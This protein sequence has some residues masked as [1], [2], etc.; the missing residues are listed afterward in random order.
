MRMNAFENVSG[1]QFVLTSEVLETGIMGSRESTRKRIILPIHRSQ[2][3]RVQR[4]LNFLQPGT[5]IRP[6]M[7][8][9]GHA[10]ESLVVLKGKIRFFRFTQKGEVISSNILQAGS[11]HS[12]ADIEPRVWH[13]FTV[14]EPDSVL[15]ECK[16]GP[17]D[18]ETDKVY[19][20]WAPEEGAG[21]VNEWLEKLQDHYHG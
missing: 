11:A 18:A 21:E 16:Q 10:T 14:L 2:D 1:D 15:F 12:V 6:H 9:L 17:Y 20:G 8:P 7:H 5:Y 13:T 19:A 4:M 3:A